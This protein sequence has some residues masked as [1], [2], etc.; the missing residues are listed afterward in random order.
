MKCKHQRSIQQASAILIC[1][2][3][4]LGVNAAERHTELHYPFAST[5]FEDG[6]VSPDS[7]YIDVGDPDIDHELVNNSFDPATECS[8]PRVTWPTTPNELGFSAWYYETGGVGLTES[9]GDYFGVTEYTGYVGSYTDGIRGYQMGD[10]DGIVELRFDTVANEESAYWGMSVDLFVAVTA[11]ENADQLEVSLLVDS[12]IEIQVMQ[13]QGENIEALAGKWFSIQYD[14]TP[15]TSAMLSIR[16]ASSADAELIFI[17]NVRFNK[18]C[19]FALRGVLEDCNQ[20]GISDS[21]EIKSG[22]IE[23]C[24]GNSIP[25]SCDLSTGVMLDL[26]AD[27]LPDECYNCNADIQ[28]DGQV[29][30]NDVLEVISNWGPCD[31]NTPPAPTTGVL[32]RWRPDDIRLLSWNMYNFEPAAMSEKESEPYARVLLALAPDVIIFQEVITDADATEL[33]AWLETHLDPGP[34]HMHAGIDT[35][36]RNVIASRY[37]LDML[38]TQTDP[39]PLNSPRGA[40]MAR[41][42]CPDQAWSTDIYLIGAHFKAFS[43]CSEELQRQG[44]ADSIT[45]WIGDLR[46]TGGV[47]DLPSGTPIFLLGD[48]NFYSE[49]HQPERTLLTGDIMDEERFG[50]DI[51]G[52]WDGSGLAD[53]RPAQSESSDTW[54]LWGSDD[55]EPSRTDRIITTNSVLM[56]QNMFSLNTTVLTLDVL[57]S[58]GLELNDTTP[59]FTSDHLPLVVDV[60]DQTHCPSDVN[61]D[62]LVGVDDILEII[63]SWGDCP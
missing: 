22:I 27:G 50:P 39:P 3:I 21:C 17:D 45:R 31:K 16:L 28:G 58:Y 14:L 53:L 48:L 12:G 44:A 11:W 55:Y 38:E 42:D 35:S 5:S 24:N 6:L 19:D 52:D 10:T 36:I 32:D 40:T 34:W 8:E 37:E 7:R 9:D 30:V 1:L 33:Q 46:T 41:V 43:G 47:V 26:N 57:D 2:M 20:N 18:S 56:R 63:S 59:D 25:D 4:S 62:G 60:R 61:S 54:T 23:D 49:G 51:P 15:Y 13:A 29:N